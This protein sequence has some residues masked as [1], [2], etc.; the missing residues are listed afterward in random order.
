MNWGAL[1]G[2][3]VRELLK[4]L[5]KD[6]VK[7]FIDGGLDRLEDHVVKT[8]NKVDDAAVLPLC[9]KI[10]EIFDIPDND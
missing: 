1:I 2:A 9:A 4:L 8:E 3:L 7:A 5:P 6:A 10:R